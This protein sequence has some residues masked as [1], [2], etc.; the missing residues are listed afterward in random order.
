M[1]IEKMDIADLAAHLAVVDNADTAPVYDNL[2][3]GSRNHLRAYMGTLRYNGG[4]CTPVHLSQ[5]AFDAIV[6]SPRETGF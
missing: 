2:L 5:T 1:L 6:N 4:S 3:R